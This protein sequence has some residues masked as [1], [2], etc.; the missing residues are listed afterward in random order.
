MSVGAVVA[1]TYKLEALIGRGGMGE[2]Y[3][4]SHLRLPGKQVAIKFLHPDVAD[5]EILA[6]FRRE[7][8][9]ASRLGH[10]NI[11]TVLDFNSLPD[12]TPYLVLEY[13]VGETLDDALAH[14]PFSVERMLAVARQLGSALAAAHRAGV[15]HRDLKPQNIFLVPTEIDGR[16][17]EVAKILDFG[18]SK[19]RGSQTVKT[20]DSALLGTPQYMSPEQATGQHDSV[21]GRTDIFAL[22][23]I[24]YEMLSG[25]AAFAGASIP[26]VVFK[27][28]YEPAP[29][30]AERVAGVP[31]EIVAAV[32]RAMAKKADERFATVGELVTALTGVG[33]ATLPPPR[34]PAPGNM[35][36]GTGRKVSSAD[37]LAKT[38]GSGDHADALLATAYDKSTTGGPG[39]SGPGGPGGGMHGAGGAMGAGSVIG[40]GTGPA[41]TMPHPQPPPHAAAGASRWK[42]I[43]IALAALTAAVIAFAALRRAPSQPPQVATAP[44]GGS[45]KPA[46]NGAGAVDAGAAPGTTTDSGARPP[47]DAGAADDSGTHAGS[48]SPT[49][50]GGTTPDAGAPTTPPVDAGLPTTPPVD[51]GAGDHG[52]PTTPKPPKPPTTPKPPPTPTPPGE[53]SDEPDAGDLGELAETLAKA[54]KEAERDP[55][56]AKKLANSI[57][58][59]A[60][61]PPKAKNQ[62]HQVIALV[63]CKADDRETAVRAGRAAGRVLRPKVVKVCAEHDIT[64]RRGR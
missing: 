18:I 50:P 6:R 33:L 14:G 26:E 8:E 4:A 9:I 41:M 2:V 60:S 34:V 43:A 32:E 58:D 46:G 31:P 49:T 5:P 24:L 23:A 13:L 54:W 44:G 17:G 38:M 21:D 11:V 51:A 59:N 57:I 48:G 36:A 52:K 15:V 45:D 63:A 28:V 37:A 40:P 55:V 19:I 20:Q 64:L 39:P 7:A 62:A 25:Q 56:L 61:A 35:A 29:P 47:G 27:V 30:L 22:G 16:V 53:P 1:E 10:P 3:A 42:W 12:G